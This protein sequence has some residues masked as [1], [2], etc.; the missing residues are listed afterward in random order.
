MGKYLSR[1]YGMI[2][3]HSI[4]TN[5]YKLG[6]CSQ[7]VILIN[8][9]RSGKQKTVDAQKDEPPKCPVVHPVVQEPEQVDKWKMAVGK[10]AIKNVQGP[11]IGK[12]LLNI[13]NG[14]SP[15][16]DQANILQQHPGGTNDKGRVVKGVD[17]VVL[18]SLQ[19]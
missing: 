11:R 7:E 19:F 2:G 5:V 9:C 8:R 3:N 4:A 1:K 17:L 13:T 16:G 18:K 10:T 6:M 14:F 15:L 12:D